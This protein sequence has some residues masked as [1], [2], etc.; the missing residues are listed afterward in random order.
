MAAIDDETG[1][2]PG[3][4]IVRQHSRQRSVAVHAR[5]VRSGSDSCPT[6][7]LLFDVS[8]ESGRYGGMSNLLP[9]RLAVVSVEF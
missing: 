6:D 4:G 3:S 1:H 2:P 8:E 5:K 7:R 9:Q